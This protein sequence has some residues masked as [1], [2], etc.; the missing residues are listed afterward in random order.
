METT[1]FLGIRYPSEQADPF[2]DEYVA[3]MQDLDV[4]LFHRKIQ[5]NL[6]IGDG[7]AL[8]WNGAGVLTWSA[9]FVV[10]VFYWGRRVLVRFGPDN[11]TRAVTLADGQAL[12]VNMP[13]VMNADV[14]VNFEVASQLNPA[15]H[16]QWVAGWRIGTKLQL[17][18][19]GEL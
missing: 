4:I 18:G 3:Q 2:W 1:Q 8:A 15:V 16:N 12:V 6:F 10:P 9:D 7:G 19:I 17:K 13:T 5:N 11:L 14:V